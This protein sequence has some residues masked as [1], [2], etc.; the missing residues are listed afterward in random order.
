MW[1]IV[2]VYKE[3]KLLNENTIEMEPTRTFDDLL[4]EALDYD[5]FDQPVIVQFYNKLTKNWAGVKHGLSA[6][7]ILCEKF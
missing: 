2:A 3:K 7:L 6:S 5:V 4:F 1:F